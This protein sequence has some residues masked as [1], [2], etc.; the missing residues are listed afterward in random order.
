MTEGE[1]DLNPVFFTQGKANKLYKVRGGLLR[2]SMRNVDPQEVIDFG[3]ASALS[4][5]LPRMQVVDSKFGR[6]IFMDHVGSDFLLCEF[7]PKWLLQSPDAPKNANQCRTC[8]IRKMRGQ[9][10]QFCPLQLASKF[11]LEN[12]F[13]EMGALNHIQ[14]A[15][16]FLQ[17]PVLDLLISA[18]TTGSVYDSPTASFLNA[19][20]ARDVTIIVEGPKPRI[21]IVDL[22]PK[23]ADKITKWRQTETNLQPFY[24]QE[25]KDCYIYKLKED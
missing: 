20:S 11:E 4:Q 10:R 18:Q 22:D 9:P 2:V 14:V 3:K 13:S 19:M 1:S 16:A 12:L 5:Y 17:S 24:L 8:A 6:A 15:Q 23:C 25:S 21:K 7:K